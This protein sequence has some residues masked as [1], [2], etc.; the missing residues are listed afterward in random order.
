MFVQEAHQLLWIHAQINVRIP[1]LIRT[2]NVMMETIYLQMV[3]IN[4]GYRSDGIV[5]AVLVFHYVAIQF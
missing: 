5:Q 4:A 1:L 2:K 3:V